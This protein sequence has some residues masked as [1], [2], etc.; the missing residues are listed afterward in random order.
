MVRAVLRRQPPEPDEDVEVNLTGNRITVTGKREAEQAADTDTYYCCER[1][2]GTFARSFTLPEDVDAEH[3]R[4]ELK[5]GVMAIDVPKSPK[6]QPKRISI[7]GS[8]KQG[9]AK[10]K[11]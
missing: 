6:A 8:E 9:E 4:A 3:I 7:T 2:Y 10:A 11:A 5:H 1:S